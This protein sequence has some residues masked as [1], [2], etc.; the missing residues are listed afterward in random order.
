MIEPDTADP[1][2][3]ATSQV[4]L[5]TTEYLGFSS[6]SIVYLLILIVLIFLSAIMSGSEVAFFSLTQSQ[7]T[8]MEQ[9]KQKRSQQ[10]LRLLSEPGKLL[11]TILIANNVVNLGLILLSTLFV[12]SIVDFGDNEILKFVVNVVSVIFV[13]VL[14]GEVVPKVYANHLNIRFARTMAPFI[15]VIQPLFKP[16]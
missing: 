15:S 3:E 1:L 6:E 4:V 5:S 9:D 12:D 11:A 2:P 16:F 8:E 10:V 14:F 13:L 7:Q